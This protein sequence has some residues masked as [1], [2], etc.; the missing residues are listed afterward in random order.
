[1]E[2]RNSA[3]VCNFCVENRK[4]GTSLRIRLAAKASPG[5]SSRVTDSPGKK[6]SCVGT[7]PAHISV[8]I[9]NNKL[10]L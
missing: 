6:V 10:S 2:S 9:A 7:V 5:K 3:C 1:M 4:M 8:Q